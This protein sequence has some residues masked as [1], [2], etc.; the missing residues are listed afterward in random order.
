MKKRNNRLTIMFIPHYDS[1]PRSFVITHK[2]ILIAAVISMLAVVSFSLLGNNY[3]FMLSQMDELKQLRIINDLQGE[4]ILSLDEETKAISQELK[5][6]EALDREVRSILELEDF[7]EILSEMEVPEK[8]HSLLSRGTSYD[9]PVPPETTGEVREGT[10]GLYEELDQIKI[11][12][13]LT[14][15]AMEDLKVLVE[16]KKEQLA[17][18]PTIW[19]TQGRITSPF[20]ERRAPY[21][22]R[23]EFHSG[24]DIGA[25]RGTPVYATARGVVEMAA[26]NG[27]MGRMVTIK[28]PYEHR[29]LFAHL[30]NY[31]VEAGDSVEKGDLIGHVGSTGFSTGPHLHYEVHVN[32]QPMDPMLFI[33][34]N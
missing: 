12:L 25:S 9:F 13:P 1:N 27:G 20:G 32:G 24:I 11:E 31:V 28:H 14:R 19:P 5:S 21:S 6:I 30:T 33:P 29:T 8:Q 23:I 16:D 26:Y 17:G 3:Y 10:F 18:T 34:Q 2:A 15:A 7:Q 22:R 4:Q